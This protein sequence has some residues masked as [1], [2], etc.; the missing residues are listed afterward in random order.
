M[1]YAKDGKLKLLAR[2]LGEF[3]FLTPLLPESL[4]PE[5]WA[6]VLA[7]CQAGKFKNVRYLPDKG[8]CIVGFYAGGQFNTV[9]TISRNWQKAIRIAD[10]IQY[11]FGPYRLR[12]YRENQPDDFNISP[13]QALADWTHEKILV[14]VLL[15][16]EKYL[17]SQQVLATPGQV[18]ATIMPKPRQ[19]SVLDSLDSLHAKL[20]QL[21]ALY[22]K[23]KNG[24]R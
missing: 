17:Q 22:E 4:E 16:V 1:R 11:R 15:E 9:I 21:I 14:P 19:I 18:P 7:R 10:M 24:Q 6:S 2:P 5:K 13:A 12:S 23:D 20:D 3:D 8:S